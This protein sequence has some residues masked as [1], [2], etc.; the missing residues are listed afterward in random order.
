MSSVTVTVSIPRNTEELITNT[1]NYA[2][3]GDDSSGFAA[4]VK[5]LIAA[6][7][8][9]KGSSFPAERYTVINL[10]SGARYSGESI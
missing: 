3:Q 2:V 1:F 6:K 7:W 8:F 10:D 5:T 9:I 4:L